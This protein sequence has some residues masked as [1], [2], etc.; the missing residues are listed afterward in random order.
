MLKF[1]KNYLH[2]LILSICILLIFTVPAHGKQDEWKDKSIEFSKIKTII[3]FV[4]IAHKSVQDPLAT[5]KVWDLS[6]EKFNA[7]HPKIKFISVRE[8]IETLQ[9][10]T[11]VDIAEL[12]KN[13][14]KKALNF[15]FENLHHYCDATLSIDILAMGYSTTYMEGYTFPV[16]TYKTTYFDASV[17]SGRGGNISG[18]ST[19]PT[20]EYYSVP[21]GNVEVVNVG[22][23]FA[24]YDPSTHDMIWVFSDIRD[25][26]NSRRFDNTKTG[27]ILKRIISSTSDKLTKLFEDKNK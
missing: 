25:K 14:T 10:D 3:V 20:T 2:T 26:A 6:G 21:G 17:N 23:R 27:D 13:D 8:Y 15:I 5:L 1:K 24:L 19:T 22:I 11:G 9:N 4:P 12:T 16:T 7:N 18:S